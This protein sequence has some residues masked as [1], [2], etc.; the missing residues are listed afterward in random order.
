M[1]DLLAR[2]HLEAGEQALR[3]DAAV[4]FDD[5]H[6]HIASLL[7]Q[8][9]C[10]GEHRVGLAHTRARPEVN[11][12]LTARC[13]CVLFPDAGE[14]RVGVGALVERA[15]DHPPSLSKARFSC[16]TFTTGSPRRPNCLPCVDWAIRSRTR[17]TGSLRAVATRRA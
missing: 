5:A 14:Q 1:L 3:F 2:Q 12:E 10:L 11:L 13:A 4:R 8:P 9:L 7:T 6:G 15:L 16:S 17:S